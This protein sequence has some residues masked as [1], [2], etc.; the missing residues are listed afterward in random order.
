MCTLVC[1][2]AIT[3][4]KHG[5]AGVIVYSDPWEPARGRE[6]GRER[7]KLYPEGLGLPGD[8][9]QRS[10]LYTHTGDPLTPHYPATGACTSHYTLNHHSINSAVS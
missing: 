6:M 10:T 8:G 9:A 2:Q 5:A 3:A 4:A 1:G 7:E